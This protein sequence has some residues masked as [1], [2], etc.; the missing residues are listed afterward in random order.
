[1]LAHCSVASRHIAF[2]SSTETLKPSSSM[3][4]PLSPVPQSSRPPDSRSSVA[5]RSATR[6]GWLIAGGITQ[7]PWPSRIRLVR[8]VS[9]PRNTSGAEE[10]EYSSR[11]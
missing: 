3:A 7:M 10:C 4:V 8:C 5:I 2:L 9:A 1:M 6:A 11:K